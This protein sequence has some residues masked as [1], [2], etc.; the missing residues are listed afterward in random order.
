M[1]LIILTAGKG[2]RFLPIT[3]K[4]PKGMVPI[5]GEP[6]LKHVVAPYLP[7]VSDIIFI[8]NNGLGMQIKEYFGENYLGHKIFYKIQLEQKGTMDALMTSKDFIKD[9]ELFC[10]SNSDD[11]LKEIDIKNAIEKNTIGAGISRKSMP[12]NYLGVQIED[13]YIKGFVRHNDDKEIIE[14]NYCNGFFVLDRKV[15][16]W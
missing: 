5:L 8:V 1:K 15:F 3:E 2:L 4:I 13:E 7:H 11:L 9:D 16:E 10:V 12:K 14:D 6:L